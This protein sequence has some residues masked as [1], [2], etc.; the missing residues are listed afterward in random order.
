MLL[1]SA[2]CVG[3]LHQRL[4]ELYVSPSAIIYYMAILTFSYDAFYG[5]S[6]IENEIVFNL[7]IFVLFFFVIANCNY[8]Q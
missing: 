2:I 8:Q 5:I 6:L 3:I 7:Y 4:D 1:C